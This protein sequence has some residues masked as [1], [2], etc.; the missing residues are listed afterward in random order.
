MD[1]YRAWC[2]ETVP[3]A[4]RTVGEEQSVIAAGFEGS[5][6]AATR[7]GPAR[8]FFVSRMTIAR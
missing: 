4:R 6:T 1:E 8:Y 2:H 5:Q 3:I 7:A